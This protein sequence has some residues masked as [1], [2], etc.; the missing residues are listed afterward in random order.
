MATIVTS[1]NEEPIQSSTVQ[2]DPTQSSTLS[3]AQTTS[4]TPSEEETPKRF[5]T[6][7]E[8]RDIIGQKPRTEET[9]QEKKK[10]KRD[11]LFAKIGD[12]FSAFHNAYSAAMGTK[13]MV[14]PNVSMSA[15]VRERYDRLQKEREDNLKTYTDAYMR[16]MQLE[17]YDDKNEYQ[18]LRDLISNNF[19]DREIKL[20]EDKSERE[21][22]LAKLKKRLLEGDI[23][24][25]EYDNEIK[26]IEAEN[27]EA[28]LKA[29]INKDNRTGSGGGSGSKGTYKP[30]GTF[31]GRTYQ[32]KADYEKA[33][34]SAAQDAGVDQTE[35]VTTTSG[36]GLDRKTT[37]R[38]VRRKIAD[39]A[40]DVEKKAKWSNTAKL[41]WK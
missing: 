30:Y 38:K 31:S 33:V 16:A 22:E 32:T 39:V 7:E 11:E 21:D 1:D 4:S 37:E 12:G 6:F 28:M 25:K 35:T 8:L 20:K 27:R 9:E 23:T 24:G 15:K 36:T 5:F 18:K 10:R 34:S 3:S 17:R 26:R 41:K 19:K 40:R 29:K 2:Q 14:N 13:S